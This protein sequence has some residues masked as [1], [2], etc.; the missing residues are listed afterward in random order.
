M[1]QNDEDLKENN[2]DVFTVR[3]DFG[4]EEREYTLEEIN[5]LAKQAQNYE[6]ILSDW[7]RIKSIAQN[8]GKSV[9]E[10]IDALNENRL[11]KRR[12]ELLEKGADEQLAEYVLGLENEKKLKDDIFFEEVLEYFPKIKDISELP[13]CVLETARLKGSRILDELLR[14]RHKKQMEISAFKDYQKSVGE[15]SIG[16]QREHISTDFDPAKLQFIKGIWGK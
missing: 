3:L 4:G 12:N 6:T 16:P 10:Y 2:A 5:A 9:G 13:A 7:Q 11:N 14:Y 8:E 15:S 1:H